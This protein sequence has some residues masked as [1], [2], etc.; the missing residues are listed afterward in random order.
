MKRKFTIGLIF[1]SMVLLIFNGCVTPE[2][3][4]YSYV[5]SD[6]EP[7]YYQPEPLPPVYQST[8]N[9]SEVIYEADNMVPLTPDII[10]RLGDRDRLP[11]NIGKYQF[12]LSGRITMES[13]Y[14]Q[15]NDRV[16]QGGRVRFEDIHVR[17]NITINDQTE[18][19]GINIEVFGNEIVISVCFEHEDRYRLTFS[20]M[21]GEPNDYF[22][23]RY[24]PV[25]SLAPYSDEKGLIEYGG[26]SYRLRYSGDKRPHL[27]ITL[28]HQDTVKLNARTVTGRRIN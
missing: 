4:A 19:Q 18:G 21:A 23:L 16:I 28:T 13:E 9:E 25:R 20:T 5:Q 22:Y 6:L 7:V 15:P 8:Y 17:D 2:P 26:D 11:T 3:I 10:Y 14:T 12:V 27:M 24:N 1:L